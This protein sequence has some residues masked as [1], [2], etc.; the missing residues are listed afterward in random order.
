[1]LLREAGLRLAAGSPPT[2]D[3]LEGDMATGQDVHVS[4]PAVP[5]ALGGGDGSQAHPFHS[6]AA[7]IT[8]AKENGGGIVHLHGGHYVE[9]VHLDEVLP[10]DGQKIVVCPAGDGEVFIDSMLP[11]FLAPE[12][13]EDHWAQVIP[14]DGVFKGEY[15]W[16]RTYDPPGSDIRAGWVNR[17]AFLD[18]PGHTRLV[19]Y[20][21]LE[22]L[23]AP[24]QIWPDDAQEGNRVWRLHPDQQHFPGLYK[25]EERS[26]R[27]HYR[28]WV[29]MGPGIW[30]DPDVREDAPGKV[31]GRR[32]H[33]R[34]APTANK[35]PGWPDYDPV[36]TD[37]NQVHLAL[38]REGEH[39]IF[40]KNSKHIRFENLTLRF[41]NPDTVRLNNCTDIVFDHCR[42]RSG[43]RAIRLQTGDDADHVN[44]DIWVEHCV[45]DG[46][47]PTWVFRSDRKDSYLFGPDA[48]DTATATRGE[49]CEDNLGY[50]TSGVQLSGTTRSK[51]VIVHHCE[52]FN[53]HDSYVFGDAMEFHHNWVHNLNDDGIAVS[54]EADTENAKIY[55]NVV[56]QCLT[57]LSFASPA[58]GQ[59]YLYGNL[60]DIRRPTL[61]K[62]PTGEDTGVPDSL[63]Q[64]HFFKDGADEG[65]VALFHNT[66]LVLD[67]GARGDD[68]T[69]L[70]DAGF[71]YY[72]TIGNSDPRQAFNNIMVVAYTAAED[73]KPIAFLPPILFGPTDG[74]TYFR[75]PQ[76]EVADEN[77]LVRRRVGGVT[78]DNF[79]FPGLGEY[80]Q[81]YW[82]DGAGEYEHEG[83]VGDPGFKSFDT[84][85]GRPH[86]GDDLRLRFHPESP[87]KGTAVKLPQ[88]LADMYFDATGVKPVDR[89][90]YSFT[91]ARLQVGV[92]GRRVFPW[93]HPGPWQDTHPDDLSPEIVADG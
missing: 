66:C 21:R 86:R 14:P 82:P 13:P 91:G 9:S 17:G 76:G 84:A 77:F 31:G 15:V 48:P 65:P 11:E 74:N 18:E 2:V 56:T 81:H 83:E 46:G 59:V 42:I 23:T 68:R 55:C 60:I 87:A 22:D 69:E 72:A 51:G 67:P 26:G 37:P 29:Y 36:T 5:G 58:V 50:A 30:F 71:A 24:G 90:C 54:A 62:R 49:L 38:S 85:T 33:I 34:L 70:N 28:P 61:G 52:I 47:M 63:R 12:G 32:I 40:L 45:I 1:V 80:R 35:I 27:A 93:M 78:L 57:A 39:A 73:L 43:S 8:K 89:G 25:P 79:R 53:A 41:G 44:K 16:G 4:P 3:P 64:G 92:D 19:S 6:V 75:I 88:L 10:Q 20:D 7:G